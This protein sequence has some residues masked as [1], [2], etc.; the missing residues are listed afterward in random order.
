MI[1]LLPL[2]AWTELIISFAACRS[3]WKVIK[4]QG[5]LANII[6]AAE[7]E[8]LVYLKSINSKS[9]AV[10]S[11]GSVIQSSIYVFTSTTEGNRNT[12]VLMAALPEL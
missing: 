1:A 12:P 5:F 3:N 9:E 8:I 4:R 2:Q 11:S 10:Q 6:L 7:G